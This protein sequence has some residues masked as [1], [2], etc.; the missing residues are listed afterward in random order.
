[1]AAFAYFGK[2]LTCR[3]KEVNSPCEGA[4]ELLTNLV[5]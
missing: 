3:L 1:M 2:K 4:K 5:T